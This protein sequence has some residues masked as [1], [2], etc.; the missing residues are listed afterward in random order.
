[1]AQYSIFVSHIS[2]E[3][4]LALL[5][6]RHIGRDFL[7]II[8]VFASSDTE[9]IAA[10]DNWLKSIEQAL[11]RASLLLVLCSPA[12]VR[13]PWINFE[14]GAAWMKRS[15]IIPVCHSGLQPRDLPMPLAIL[16]AV[17][18]STSEGLQNIYARIARTANT[19][20]P[21]IDSAAVVVEVQTF[22]VAYAPT[23]PPLEQSEAERARMALLRMK[24]VLEEPQY[25]YRG[26][27]LLAKRAAIS[28]SEA[29][30]ILRADPD[31]V[32]SKS[33][34]GEVI[35]RLSWR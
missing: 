28:E 25:R 5:L 15:P 6:K 19:L 21:K 3:A 9:S 2:E 17:V 18:A 27:K 12:S 29:E 16:Q 30:D 35:A 4:P 20:V 10:G 23:I 31:I 22:E 34:A 7:G 8:D 14:A 33:E 11:D 13:R 32:F 24:R 26:I 1:M